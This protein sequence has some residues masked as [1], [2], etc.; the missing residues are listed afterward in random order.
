MTHY[1]STAHILVINGNNKHERLK[2]IQC[3]K[4]NS[5]IDVKID[6]WQ[7][8]LSMG[9]IIGVDV[10][11]VGGVLD[12]AFVT[13]SAVV[14]KLTAAPAALQRQNCAV[15]SDAIF[16]FKNSEYIANFGGGGE[17]VFL[18]HLDLLCLCLLMYKPCENLPVR[19]SSVARF[20]N[21]DHS[22]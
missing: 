11:V 6:I 12:V 7:G 5:Y 1:D 9:V 22:S 8:Y 10:I 21:R 18:G 17:A 2:N 16:H 4:L 14:R 13:Q 20:C 19:S 3:V 15:Q